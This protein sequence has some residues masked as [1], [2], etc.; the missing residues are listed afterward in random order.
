M[1][2]PAPPVDLI[3][4][5][6]FDPQEGIVELERHLDRLGEAARALGFV[7]NRHDAR[8]ELQAATFG[9]RQK[10][11]ARMMLS[12]TGAMAVEVKALQQPDSLPVPVALNRRPVA[13]DDYRLRFKTTDREFFDK[14]RAEGGAY[15]TL[16]V[17]DEGML[18]E[19]TF[20][21]IFVERGEKL[22]TPPLS[23]G[24][25]PGLLRAKLIEEGR[26]EEADLTPADLEGG[27]FIGNMVRGLIPARLAD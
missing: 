21:S 17:D 3:E 1:T 23:R 2:S 18:T 11:I 26:A 16:F 27:F 5:M 20:S 7:Y 24:L 8:N 14:A 12:P 13:S 19:G 15:E 10:G 25:L 4:T 9:R 6:G 22:L